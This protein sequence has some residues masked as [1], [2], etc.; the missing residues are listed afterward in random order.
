MIMLYDKTKLLL[1]VS[2]ILASLLSNKLSTPFF[3]FES[4]GNIDYNTALALKQ[5]GRSQNNTEIQSTMSPIYQTNDSSS[6]V[7]TLINK[8]NA[9]YYLGNYTEAIR[10]YDKALTLDPKDSNAL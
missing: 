10:Y 8:A 7:S 5:P 3:E 2:L 1:I 9:L 6:D 4:K